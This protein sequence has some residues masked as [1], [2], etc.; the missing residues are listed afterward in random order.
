[1]VSLVE[2][3]W[4]GLQM[5][6]KNIGDKNMEYYQFGGQEVFPEDDPAFFERCKDNLTRINTML[7]RSSVP[8]SMR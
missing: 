6:R 3:R 8:M 5:L 1:M 2:K 4:N 7:R